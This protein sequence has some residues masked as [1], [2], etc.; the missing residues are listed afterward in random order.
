VLTGTG[1][2]LFPVRTKK[3][4]KEKEKGRTPCTTYRRRRRGGEKWR[5]RGGNTE[6]VPEEMKARKGGKTK[7]RLVEPEKDK[8]SH[9]DDDAL[10][11]LDAPSCP[12]VEKKSKSGY[13]LSFG[14]KSVAKRWDHKKGKDDRLKAKQRNGREETQGIAQGPLTD[15]RWGKMSR[16]TARDDQ[17]QW[18]RYPGLH[19]GGGSTKKIRAVSSAPN[20]KCGLEGG[21]FRKTEQNLFKEGGHGFLTAPGAVAAGGRGQVKMYASEIDDQRNSEM[22]DAKRKGGK[23][24]LRGMSKA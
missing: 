16:V 8:L 10:L 23:H 6:K 11:R 9:G 21:H 18:D 13:W 3:S 14:T 1:E 12:G 20:S 17:A 4:R 19:G 5:E 2:R 24:H 7:Q 15:G 22:T